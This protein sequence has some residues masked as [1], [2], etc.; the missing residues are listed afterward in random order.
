MKFSIIRKLIALAI[1]LSSFNAYTQVFD[2]YV[3]DAGNFNAPPWQI[4]RYDENGENPSVF[5]DQNLYWP[6]DILFLEDRN[7][8]LISN[9]G[10]G[11]INVHDAESGDFISVFA[12]GLAGPTRLK[13]GPDSQL[14]VLLWEGNERV[15]RYEPNGTD[16]GPFISGGVKSS[17][18]IDWDRH[19]NLYLF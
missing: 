14:Y 15:H 8:V 1:A 6:Q 3:S 12:Q 16:L 4:V 9:F 19:G 17:I 13:I 5:I 7:I 18:G 11:K 2:I 10:S